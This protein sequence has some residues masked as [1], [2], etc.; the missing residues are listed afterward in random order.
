MDPTRGRVSLSRGLGRWE[1]D[2][3]P[4]VGRGAAP[5]GPLY[6]STPAVRRAQDDYRSEYDRRDNREGEDRREYVDVTDLRVQHLTELLENERRTVRLLS[7]FSNIDL[8]QGDSVKMELDPVSLGGGPFP[9][10]P[11]LENMN[12]MKEPEKAVEEASAS[13]LLE[14]AGVSAQDVY[15]QFWSFEKLLKPSPVGGRPAPKKR[16]EMA[17]W[18]QT[19][20]INARSDGKNAAEH[21]YSGRAPR[22]KPSQYDGQTPYEDYQVQ[23][24]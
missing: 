17:W 12:G 8:G 14:G 13:G 24:I 1:V 16:R 20:R 5:T 3:T 18:G 4:V 9:D 7:H 10:M 22:M 6:T 2:G 15:N 19:E 11:V 21:K 23:F